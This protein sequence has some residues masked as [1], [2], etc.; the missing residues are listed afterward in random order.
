MTFDILPKH[1]YKHIKN[2]IYKHLT[3]YNAKNIKMK[4]SFPPNSVSLNPLTCARPKIVSSWKNWSRRTWSNRPWSKRTKKYK[5]SCRSRLTSRISRSP[6]CS[7][8]CRRRRPRIDL[9]FNLFIIRLSFVRQS[10]I[11]VKNILF[12]YIFLVFLKNFYN[13]IFYIF[14]FY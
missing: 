5:T 9:I 2:K 11:E 14:K 12:L 10:F 13:M 3:G 8:R 1:I 6:G 7:L 4:A